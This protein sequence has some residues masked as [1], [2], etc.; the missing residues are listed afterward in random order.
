MWTYRSRAAHRAVFSSQPDLE[1]LGSSHSPMGESQSAVNII[2]ERRTLIEVH[3]TDIR[4]LFDAMDPSPLQSRDLDPR[5]DAFIVDWAK[6]LPGES[7]ITLVVYIDQLETAE[8]HQ[9]VATAVHR[10]FSAKAD[11]AWRSLRE[12]FA[13]ARVSLAIG[14]TCLA[15]SLA[16]SEVIKTWISPDGL[17]QVLRES[18]LIGGWVAMWRPMELLLYDWWPIRADARLLNQLATMPVEIRQGAS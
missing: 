9:M 17:A 2:D 18:L 10:H 5:T 3:V 16:A 7:A 11:A 1:C 8:N 14:L 6:D 13:R 15:I 12:L 4:Q